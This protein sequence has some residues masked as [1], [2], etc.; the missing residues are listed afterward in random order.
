MFIF[1]IAK[2]RGLHPKTPSFFLSLLSTFL[3]PGLGFSTRRVEIFTQRVV[4][5]ARRVVATTR[6]FDNLKPSTANPTRRAVQKAGT[7]FTQEG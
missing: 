1:V 3:K 4:N 2:G 7:K 6:R 5:S